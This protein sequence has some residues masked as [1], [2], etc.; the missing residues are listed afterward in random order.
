MAALSQMVCYREKLKHG[1]VNLNY[2]SVLKAQRQTVKGSF[3]RTS[4]LRMIFS[5]N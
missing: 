3:R 5:P 4:K 1:L 2:T